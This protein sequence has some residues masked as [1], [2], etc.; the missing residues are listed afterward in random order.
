[1]EIKSKIWYLENFSLFDCLSPDEMKLL[2]EKTTMRKKGKNE[3]IYFPEEPS[4][5]IFL[6]KKGKVKI[7]TYSPD[8]KEIIKTILKEGEIFGEM[9]IAGEEKRSDFAQSIDE[10]VILCAI[11]V[12]EMENIMK[13]NPNLS[14]RI[15]KLIGF[16]FR[17][18]ERK[19]ESLIFKDARARLL[20]FIKEMAIENGQKVGDEILIKFKLTHQDIGNLTAISRQTV[21]AILNQL[22]REGLIKLERNAILIHDI[23][24][25]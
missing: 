22:E 6:L 1:M 7:G 21:T 3:F 18:I 2:S 15:T 23:K 10:D 8:G 9:S 19:F 17:K 4:S 25:I 20:D 5:S 14:L 11:S 16:R 12:K 24:K 13:M